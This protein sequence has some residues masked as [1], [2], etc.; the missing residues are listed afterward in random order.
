MAAAE[1]EHIGKAA[2]RLHISQSPLSRQIRQLEE[3]LHLELF[4]RERQRV[5]LTES[6]K[7][8]LGHARQLLAYADRIRDEAEQ[9]AQGQS[10][11]LSISFVSGAMW[12]GLLPKLLRRFQAEFPDARIE[13]SNLRSTPQMEAIASGRIDIGFV[14]V[15]ANSDAIETTCLAEEPM[16][17]VVP[18][19]HPLGRKRTIMPHDLDGVRWIL[20][21]YST[22]TNWHAQFM[23]ACA[24][25][26][27][28]PKVIQA[29]SEPNTLLSLVGSEL[30][31][32]LIQSSARNYAPRAVRFRALPWIPLKSRIYMIR[33][34]NGSQSL[35]RRFAAYVSKTNVKK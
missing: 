6:G 23:A 17:L 22:S 18:A 7:W 4:E 5:R 24:N 31:V 35:A 34:T 27:F 26:G 30:G 32:G 20:L 19:S 11:T 33:P 21:S 8:L 10:G 14:S 9:R 2:E 25:A 15:P 13:L 1:L 12:S 29:V 28:T 3:E 16:A